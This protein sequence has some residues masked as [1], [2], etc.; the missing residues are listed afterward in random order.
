[1][2]WC[3]EDEADRY[4]DRVLEAMAEARAA[5]PSIWPLEVANV[6]VVAE[7][8]GRLAEADSARFVELLGSLAIRVEDM[9][10]D[11]ATG[12]IL[13]LARERKLSTYDAS[14]LELAMRTGMPLATKD[15]ALRR[16]CRKTGVE[17]FPP[18]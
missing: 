9:S 18:R 3:F 8:R 6:L 7:R 17:V 4:S 13:A 14:Y 10:F 2:A 5:V 12:S 15:R 1:M 11:K 16:A